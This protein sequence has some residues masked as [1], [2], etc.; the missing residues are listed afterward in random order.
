MA[1]NKKWVLPDDKNGPGWIGYSQHSYETLPLRTEHI[2]GSEV[3][4]FRDKA[5]D[6]YF[7]NQDYLSM[8]KKLLGNKQFLI[9]K[10]CP[11]IS[12]KESIILKSKLLEFKLKLV[13]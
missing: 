10:K 5:F 8:I 9:L 7:K 1:K 11:H 4:E 2:K 6:A 12:S 13:V 3:L